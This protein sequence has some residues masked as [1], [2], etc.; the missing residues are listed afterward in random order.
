MDSPSVESLK[1]FE[2]DIANEF[3]AGKIRAPIHLSGN[4]EQQLIDIFRDVHP[5]D[6]V[7]CQWRSHYHCLLKGVPPDE[8]KAAIMAG[9]SISLCFPDHRIFSS[10]IAGG[11][12]PI[13][14]GVAW[15]IKREGGK[16]RVW[17][18]L[19]DMVSRMGIYQECMAYAHGHDLPIRFV[20]EDNGK[21]VCTDTTATWESTL[22]RETKV[23]I[24]CYELPWPHAGAG[25]RVQF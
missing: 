7:F 19:G 24:Y 15:Q 21:S 11:H 23:D 3:N 14:L 6:W 8:L 5:E 12:L 4:N 20:I 16:E 22:A 2:L 10:A 9:R 17:A 13:A 1:A 25:V 18:F